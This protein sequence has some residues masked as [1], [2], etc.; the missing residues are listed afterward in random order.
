MSTVWIASANGLIPLRPTAYAL[1]RHLQDLI[2]EH[3]SLLASAVRGGD[4]A[5]AWLLVQA[6]LPIPYSA[7]GEQSLTWSLD[8]LFV[9]EHG[10]PTLVEV[11]RSSD[12]RAR[13]EVVAQMLDYA[14][15]FRMSFS[16]KDLRARAE[17]RSQGKASIE[18]FLNATA[19]DGPDPFWEA[20]ETKIN[21]SEL[22]LVFVADRLSGPLVRLIEMLNEQLRTVEVVG[23]EVVP[24]VGPVGSSLRAFVPVV[25]GQ[26][27]KV[28]PQKLPGRRVDPAEFDAVLR[29]RS[30]DAAVAAVHA[31]LRRTEEAGGWL[32]WGSAPA[33][34]TVFLTWRSREP[35]KNIWPVA[36]NAALG[37]VAIQLQWLKAHGPFASEDAR[38]DLVARFADAI[39]S[40]IPV[41][42]YAGR[43]GF[44]VSVLEK[45]GVLDRVMDVILDCVARVAGNAD[46]T[47]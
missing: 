21:A 25:R 23:V 38:V 22:R 33:T 26:T 37:K 5:A 6:E 8:H 31:L 27:A 19:F 28:A 29:A 34:P 30:G 17:A 16:A 35:S 41:N 46:P 1:E 39:G 18:T 20:V 42:N 15:S 11:K 44:D 36:V 47:G 3:P 7:D 13:R 4:P 40:S 43:P 32:D 45:P 14:A 24:H 2:A 9:D 12:S 10:T